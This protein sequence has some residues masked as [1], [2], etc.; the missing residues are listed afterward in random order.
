MMMPHWTEE[1]RVRFLAQ[2]ELIATQ[3]GPPNTPRIGPLRPH[4][5][6]QELSRSKAR[7]VV[8]PA[9]RRS[10]KTER[11]KRKLVKESIIV[12]GYDDAAFFAG[13]P[14]RDQ[15]K[16]I[17][18]NDLKRMYPPALIADVSESELRIKLVTGTSMSVIGMDKPQ[19]MEGTPW[20]G[21]V[22]DEYAN[23]KPEAWGE[24]VRPALSDRN[25]WCW[26]IGVPEGRNHYYDLY[27]RAVANEDGEWAAFTW[28]SIEVLPEREIE[29]LRRDLDELSFQQ[30]LEASFVNFTGRAYY[31]FDPELNT[32]RLKYNP[33]R[34][35]SF[36]FDFNVDPGVAVV[37]QEQ[38][39]PN[40][41]IVTGVIG[42]VH[43]P[44][45]ST[46]EAVCRRLIKDWPD[47]KG[48]IFCFG[49]ASGGNR[50]TTQTRG[51]DW[52]IIKTE[53]RAHYGVERVHFRIPS[54][55]PSERARVNA[56]NSRCRSIAGERKLMVDPSKAPQTAVDLEGVRLLTGGSGEID[57]KYDARLTH[58]SDALGYYVY[59]E[60]PVLSGAARPSD[61]RM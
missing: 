11:A 39:L 61:F 13:A 5:K 42:E 24:N 35:L 46:T 49:D 9:G 12:Q 45:N 3:G 57:K 7:F 51:S 48:N 18:W 17:W 8:V 43:I 20:N 44:V 15:A 19:R 1:Q 54:H 59:R 41:L 56:V 53:L 26:L 31:S 28:K 52:D 6:G 32:C 34:M 40:G 27:K 22:L 58:L 30:E 36:C 37:V 2:P 50:H 60:H 16:R 10:G 4:P 14:T 38:P 21:G 33:T 55:N 29:S 25:G 47:H 23:M